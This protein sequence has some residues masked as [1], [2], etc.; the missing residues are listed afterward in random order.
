[1][2]NSAPTLATDRA[3]PLATIE[4]TVP[5][6]HALPPGCL[7]EPRCSYRIPECRTAP[8]PLIEVAPAHVARCPVINPPRST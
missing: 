8:P 2:L 1:M 3:K 4:G 6:L 5:P 7:F